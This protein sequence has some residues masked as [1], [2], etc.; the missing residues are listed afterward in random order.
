MNS[1][2]KRREMWRK[3]RMRGSRRSREERLWRRR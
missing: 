1:K 3:R 2:R